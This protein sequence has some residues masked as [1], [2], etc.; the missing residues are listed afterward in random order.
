MYSFINRIRNYIWLKSLA[1]ILFGLF[2]LFDPHGTL[3][4]VINLIA[5]FFIVFGVINLISA[6]RQRARNEVTDYSLAIGIT[7]LVIAVIVFILAV[8]LLSFL[9][10]ILGI[11]L[12]I[13]GASNIFTALN[14]RQYVNVSPMPFVLYGVLLILVGIM[15]AF[16][17]FDTILILLQFFGATLIV[18]GIMEIVTAWQLRL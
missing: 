12:V 11:V 9:P 10:F 15:L 6:W 14:H 13:T 18:M 8:P 17:P 3:N 1:Y 4:I 16:N 7:Q 2:F 5:S